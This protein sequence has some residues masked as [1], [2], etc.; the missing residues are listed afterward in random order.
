MQLSLLAPLELLV[1]VIMGTLGLGSLQIV[2]C[3]TLQLSNQFFLRHVELFGRR[4][5]ANR[6]SLSHLIHHV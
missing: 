2:A 3:C 6:I 1:V 4:K 5:H